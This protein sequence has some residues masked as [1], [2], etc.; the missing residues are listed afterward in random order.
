M[1]NLKYKEF[2]EHFFLEFTR[3]LIRNSASIDLYKL[4]K[5]V[6]R[7][8]KKI[9]EIKG[10]IP[11]V[12]VQTEEEK[13]LRE[14][15]R[16]RAPRKEQYLS[17]IKSE[18]DETFSKTRNPFM[19]KEYRGVI[20]KSLP[21]RTLFIQEPMLPERLKYL[22]PIPSQS[23]VDL[24]KIN[25]FIEDPVVR[26]IECHG[27]D[28]EIIIS[29]TMGTK[30]TNITLTEEDIEKIIKKF[31]EETRI[32]LHEGFFKAALG[33]VIISAIYSESI[34]SKFIIRKMLRPQK[35]I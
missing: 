11:V 14:L 9:K 19:T 34:G 29:G 6:S 22:K 8:E 15:I 35:A 23:G 26:V 17:S 28:R 21:G 27:P 1:H 30:E 33:K 7:K 13:A 20:K 16:K 2:G 24:E 25:T 18:G 3:E 12:I 5:L 31:S 32:P 10:N 4:D